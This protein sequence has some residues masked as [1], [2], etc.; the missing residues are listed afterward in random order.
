MIESKILII[1]GFKNRVRNDRINPIPI[2]ILSKV[3][4]RM[5]QTAEKLD[6]KSKHNCCTNTGS[7]GKTTG[8][9]FKKKLVD[10]TSNSRYKS[11]HHEETSRRLLHYLIALLESFWAGRMASV[12]VLYRRGIGQVFNMSQAPQILASITKI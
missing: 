10:T 8:K 9:L 6:Y 12:R 5:W 7:C 11:V 2:N 3:R 4:F 1:S